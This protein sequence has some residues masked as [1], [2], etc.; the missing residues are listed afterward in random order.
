MT[1]EGIRQHDLPTPPAS[2]QPHHVPASQQPCL[3]P[4]LPP[5]PVPAQY[6]NVNMKGLKH[7]TYLRLMALKDLMWPAEAVQEVRGGH[8]HSAPWRLCVAT[9]LFAAGA[10]HAQ[11]W[12]AYCT[13][14]QSW[15]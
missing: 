4:A 6:R 3:P 14:R 2:Q 10:R 15:P 12:S 11:Q 7:A 1:E 8:R 5:A 9:P 13:L